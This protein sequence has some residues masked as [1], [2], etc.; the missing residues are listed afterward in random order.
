MT[1][2]THEQIRDLLP[3]ALHGTLDAERATIVES[4]LHGCAECAAEMRVLRMVMDAPSFAPMID[5]VKV[6]SAILPYGGVPAERPRARPLVWQTALAV[7]AVVLVAVT[8]MIRGTAAPL[9]PVAQPR[10]ASVPAP[11][12]S[13]PATA[14]PVVTAKATPP[15]KELQVAV[16]LDGLS[17]G[18]IAQLSR[19]L[20]GLDGLPSAEPE[21]LGVSD[22]LATGDSGI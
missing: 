12:T 7:A 17:D 20:D 18:S 11:V 4:H 15:V 22:P 10:V 13:A 1:E 6:S 5:A 2:T 8:L 3:D 16:G 9:P 19:E 14:E 21:T